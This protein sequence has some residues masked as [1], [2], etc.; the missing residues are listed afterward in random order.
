MQ[1]LNE[2]NALRRAVEALRTRGA[3]GIALVPTMG[4]LHSGHMTLVEHAQRVADNVVVSIFVNPTQFGPKEDLSA[5]PRPFAEDQAMLAEAGVELLWNPDAAEMYPEG[6]STHISVDGLTEA[7]DGKARPGHFEGVA[8]VVAKLFNQVKPDIALFGEKDYQQLCVIRRM[9]RDLDM[10]INIIGVPTVREED[11]LALSSRN[12]YLTKVHRKQATI[13]PQAMRDAAEA[14]AGGVN[15]AKAIRV[16]KSAIKAGGFDS[17]DYL[18]LRDG[19][20][21]QPLDRAVPG[22][23]LFVAAKIGKTRLIDNWPIPLEI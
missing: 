20:L 14:I 10:T 22:A 9:V 11:G 3:N 12:R 17:I 23:R 5:Y 8:T 16:A 21:L 19:D 4:A 1:T 6:H 15:A 7:M 2:V 18:D 13:L